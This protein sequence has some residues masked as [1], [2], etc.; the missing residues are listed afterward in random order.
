MP[1]PSRAV[2]PASQRPQVVLSRWRPPLR[3]F[4]PWEQRPQAPLPCGASARASAP[5]RLCP[6]AQWPQALLPSGLPAPPAASL[7][8][9]DRRPAA[10]GTA[11]AHAPALCCLA[12]AAAGCRHADRGQQ[13]L[14][15]FLAFASTIL[16]SIF[17]LNTTHAVQKPIIR[18]NNLALIPLLGNHKGGRHHMRSGRT[19]KQKSPIP[20][21]M[22]IVVRRLV[23]K[24]RK[25][26]KTAYRDCVT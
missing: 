5:R 1:P 3:G 6:R 19:R 21:K 24:I 23:R 17:F 15:P 25:N 11:L 18:T 7:L 4:C 2:L 16:T 13:L 9:A 22:F 8:Q 10:A 20:K 14:L 26:T 12:A